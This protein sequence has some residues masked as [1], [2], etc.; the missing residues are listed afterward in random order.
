MGAEGRRLYLHIGRNKAGSTTLQDFC[1]ARAGWLAAQGIEYVL[2]GH[3][4]GSVTG[5]RSFE[6]HY[7]LLR[8][9]EA[10]RGSMLAS[11][12][13]IAGYPPAMAL[14]MAGDLAAVDARVIFYV[15]P[16]RDWVRSN[17]AYESRGG[18]NG[19]DFDTFLEGM[20]GRVSFLPAAQIW[21]G[22]LG[23]ERVRV[24]STAAADLAGGDLVTDFCAALGVAAPGDF[25]G[26]SNAAAHWM[27]VELLRALAG[28]DDGRLWDRHRLAI[29][30]ALHELADVAVAE[31]G[32]AESDAVY[33]TPGEAA[34]LADAWNEDVRVLADLSGCS[35]ARDDFGCG[36]ARPFLPSAAQVPREVLR[37]VAALAAR[38]DYARLHP[39]MAAYA[40]LR[41]W[42]G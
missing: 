21:G 27:V 13:V 6:T 1:A 19:K 22:L 16:Y 40:R 26:R 38:P 35:L 34:A 42:G 32:F 30:E 9:F 12:E 2:Y 3:L 17:Y 28:A 10:G 7:E 39:E 15:R 20:R 23:W 8:A 25:A 4:A 37:R 11:N 14:R 31:L 5:L 36:P 18:V 24:R 33:F 29:A 41:G